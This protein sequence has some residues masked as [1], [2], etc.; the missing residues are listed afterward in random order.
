MASDDLEA[1]DATIVPGSFGLSNTGA[2]CH[3]NS[4]L[5]ALVGCSAVVRTAMANRDYLS[6]TR[7]G[8]AFYDFIYT[9]VPKARLSDSTLFGPPRPVE[10]C[11]AA[12]LQAM[13]LDLRR[14]RPN[15][16]YGPSQESASEG[17]VLLLDMI[18]DPEPRPV[19][20]AD[21]NDGEGD[22]VLE[23]NPIARLFY[24][25]YEARVFCK[26]CEGCV[27]QMMDVA[28]QF[29]L[30][31]YDT[32]PK[33][34]ET[35]AEFR[36]MLR[37]QTSYLEDYRCEKCGEQAG[38]FRHYRLRMI[39]EVLVCV[40]NLYNATRRPRYFPTR[41]PFPGLDNTQ[42][43]FREVAQVEQ[44]GSLA[45]GHYTARGLRAGGEVHQFNDTSV[46]PSTFGSTPN[47]YMVFYHCERFSTPGA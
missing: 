15:F 26:K 17:L 12:V 7:T 23:E 42:H 38:G 21:N 28:V 33:K 1:Y 13:V 44:S 25:R 46:T 27:S 14:R 30:F 22:V 11:S 16:L 45:G 47:V 6:R 34:P 10:S 35:P 8:G 41:I 32:L 39:P 3:L 2:I 37:S 18:D 31:N 29:N 43:I 20:T 24:H 5:Q 19:G 9:A 40:F 36:E 4:L